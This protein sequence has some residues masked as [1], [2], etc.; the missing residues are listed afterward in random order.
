MGLITD[1]EECPLSVSSPFDYCGSVSFA[2]DYA[3]PSLLNDRFI[4]AFPISRMI[5]QR[6][7]VSLSEYLMSFYSAFMYRKLS[8]RVRF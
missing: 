1:G 8:P 7:D 5:S 2:L 3:S 6:F 4:C